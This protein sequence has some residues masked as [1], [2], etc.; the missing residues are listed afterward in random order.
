M[1]RQYKLLIAISLIVCAYG[2]ECDDAVAIYRGLKVMDVVYK[3][4]NDTDCCFLYPVVCSSSN[5][6]ALLTPPQITE[7]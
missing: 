4:R 5:D 7:L 6:G 3:P 2:S 1:K